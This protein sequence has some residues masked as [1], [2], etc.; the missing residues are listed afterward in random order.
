MPYTPT[1]SRCPFRSSE[2]PPPEP[3]FVAIRLGRDQ[4]RGQRALHVVRAPPV[5]PAVLDARLERGRHACDADRVE[6]PVQEQ[7]AAAARAAHATDDVC[8]ARR[9][10][11]DL[12]LDAPLLEPRGD[13]ARDLRL[14]RAACDERRVDRLDRNQILEQRPHAPSLR[15]GP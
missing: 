3:R 4:H 15:Y 9:E 7:R 2:R 10:L 12:D 6:V 5:E 13:E 11:V 14:A 8:A 1:V